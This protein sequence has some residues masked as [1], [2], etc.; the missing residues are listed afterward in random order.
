MSGRH[1]DITVTRSRSRRRRTLLIVGAAAAVAALVAGISA[2]FPNHPDAATP[3]A[4]ACHGTV[5]LR[6]ATAPALGGPV[7]EIAQNWM[8]EHPSVHGRCV[9]VTV[10]SDASALQERTLADSGGA[11]TDLWLPDSS[12]WA[13]KLTA[14]QAGLPGLTAAVDVRRS[15][16]ASPLVMVAA[17]NKATELNKVGARATWRQ[18]VAGKLA[19]TVADPL[20]STDGLLSLLTVEGLI[21]RPGATSTQ[22]DLISVMVR[23][24]HATLSASQVGF[25]RLAAHPDNAPMLTASEQE[26]IAANT[27]AHATVAAAVYPDE[28]T[29]AYDYPIVR[30][31][32]ADDDPALPTVAEQFEAQLRSP[33]ARARYSRVGLRTVDGT[34]AQNF[35][36]AQGVAAAPVP[37]LPAPKATQAVDI[38]RLWSAALTD[39]HTLAVIDTS[40]SMNEP[41]GNGQSKIAVASGSAVAATGFFPDTSQLGLWAFASDQGPNTP[42]AQ[43]VPLGLMTDRVGPVDRRHALVAAAQSLPGRVHGGTALYDTALAAFDAV[44]NSYDPARANSVVLLTDGQ[45]DYAA[46]ITLQALLTTLRTEVDPARPVPIITIGIGN[47]DIK[48]LQAISA[49]TGGKAYLVRKAADVRGVFLDAVAQRRC[50]PSC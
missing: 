49:A 9:D 40:G 38:L 42:W 25:D 2:V 28:G 32:H 33:D 5:G 46:G 48:A 35:G 8:A 44:R 34:L 20:S 7:T 6:V 36:A 19:M 15:L 18:I 27:A 30:L 17:P 39:T 13:H 21:H 10:T 3:K 4:V 45:N 47:A 41:A 23:I 14:D 1:I 22:L 26:V 11:G 12:L 24:S 43:L 37:S 50:R 31:R 29:L 16:A